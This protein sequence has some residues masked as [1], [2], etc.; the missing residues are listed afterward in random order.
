MSEKRLFFNNLAYDWDNRFCTKELEN[1]LSTFV[2]IFGLRSGNKVLDVGTGTGILIPYLIKEI[3]VNGQIVAI[4]YAKKMIEVCKSKYKQ[5]SNIEFRVG[6]IE[7]ID[8]SSGFF[9]FVICFGVFPHIE[10]KIQALIQIN[11]VLKKEGKLIIAHA[12]SREEI[13]NH[14]Q[15]SSSVVAQDK[16]PDE[17]KM[18]KLLNQTGFKEINITDSIGCYLCSSIKSDDLEDVNL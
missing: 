5:F 7:E 9:D 18:R 10:N 13:Q 8:Y 6:N 4:D 2:P 16:L 1:F 15:S 14:H 17:D 11:R 12:L 3:G